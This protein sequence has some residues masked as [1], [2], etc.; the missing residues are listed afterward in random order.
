MYKKFCNFFQDRTSLRTRRILNERS[1][2]SEPEF[3]IA[4][5]TMDMITTTASKML[6]LSWTYF[7]GPSPSTL[8]TISTMNAI[9]STRLMVAKVSPYVFGIPSYSIASTRV[10]TR[11][12]TT[13]SGLNHFDSII[14]LKNRRIR[15]ESV[16][17]S[18]L[19]RSSSFRARLSSFLSFFDPSS[20]SSVSSSES[21]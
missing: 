10:L 18:A 12:S 19:R 20:S 3:A 17:F 6:K 4:S 13:K 8:K 2:E 7:L 14:P 9:V 16:A 5:S 21:E 15:P 1:A 11:M